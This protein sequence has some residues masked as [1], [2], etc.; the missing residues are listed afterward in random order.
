MKELYM[1]SLQMI[2]DNKVKTKKEYTKLAQ[3]EG[4][5]IAET[6]EYLSNKKIEEL[7]QS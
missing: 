6:L 3:K 4:L 5:L 7:V 1:K 2:K